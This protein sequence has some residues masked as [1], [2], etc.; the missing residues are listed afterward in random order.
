MAEHGEDKGSGFSCSGL[1][2]GDQILWT[3][4]GGG[5]GGGVETDGVTQPQVALK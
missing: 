5:G 3:K 4:E 2:L 1:R